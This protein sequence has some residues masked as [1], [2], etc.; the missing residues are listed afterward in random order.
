[1]LSHVPFRAGLMDSY[2]STNDFLKQQL[3]TKRYIQSLLYQA[4]HKTTDIY[5]RIQ[6]KD[7]SG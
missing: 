6:P 3:P 1:M 5:A 2:D 7:L 4:S